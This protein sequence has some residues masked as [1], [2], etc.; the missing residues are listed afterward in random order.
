MVKRSDVSVK[1]LKRVLKKAGLKTT[2]RKAA[3]TRRAKKAHLKIRGGADPNPPTPPS[4]DPNPPPAERDRNPEAA[5]ENAP[6]APD[7]TS[8]QGF[9]PPGWGDSGPRGGRRRSRK[10]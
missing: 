1:I 6:E 10:H 7:G 4:A 3:L 9:Y 8:P 2:G 5:R